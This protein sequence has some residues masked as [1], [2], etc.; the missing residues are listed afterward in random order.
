MS[1]FHEPSAD[2]PLV[3]GGGAGRWSVDGE[4]DVP[5]LRQIPRS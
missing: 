4:G 2:V 3:F 1:Y 5:E